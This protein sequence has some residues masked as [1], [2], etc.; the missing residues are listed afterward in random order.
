MDKWKEIT[1]FCDEYKVPKQIVTNYLDAI[2]IGDIIMMESYLSIL[3]NQ[4]PKRLH[5]DLKKDLNEL[6]KDYFNV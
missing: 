6:A 1:N 5:S 3:Y 4:C 2:Q